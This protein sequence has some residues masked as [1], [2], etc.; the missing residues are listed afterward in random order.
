LNAEIVCYFLG[1]KKYFNLT[2]IQIKKIVEFYHNEGKELLI[3]EAHLPTYNK[4]VKKIVIDYQ[5]QILIG[6]YGF[7]SFPMLLR[8]K[9]QYTRIEGFILYDELLNLPLWL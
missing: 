2:E 1:I 9:K 3:V 7:V 4:I 6:M 8:I 5:P